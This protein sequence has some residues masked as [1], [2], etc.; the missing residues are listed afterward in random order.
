VLPAPTPDLGR[1]SGKTAKVCVSSVITRR[2][3][4]SVEIGCV[5]DRDLDDVIAGR[6]S[7][8]RDV[9]RSAKQPRLPNRFEERAPS[10]GTH[11]S[12]VIRN[13]RARQFY[14]CE[15]QA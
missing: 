12:F 7:R 4:V 10:G 8:A 9:R 1:A 15:T 2:Q 13:Q 5:N 6:A 14:K 3:D 11:A